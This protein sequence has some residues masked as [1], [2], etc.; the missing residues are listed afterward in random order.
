MEQEGLE[1]GCTMSKRP[2]LAGGELGV[3]VSVD[4]QMSVCAHMC[5]YVFMYEPRCVHTQEW[6]SVLV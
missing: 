4:P 6:V 3:C 2:G 1:G 5:L